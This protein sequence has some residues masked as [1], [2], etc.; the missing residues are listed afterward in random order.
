MLGAGPGGLQLGYYLQKSNAD[1]L[2]LDRES[3][4]GSTFQVHPR[5]RTLISINKRFT[6]SQDP[7]F[8]MR[9]DWNSLLCDDESF[10]FKNYDKQFFPS[11]DSLVTYMADYAERFDLNV[12]YNAAISSIEK[13]GNTY[14]L[15]DQ[16]GQ[17]YECECL[18]IATGVSKS[19]TPNIEGIEFSENYADMSLDLEGFEDK[20]V[21]II[22]KKNSAFESADHIVS[23]ASLIHLCS[24]QS[25]KMAWKTHYVGDLRAINNNVLDTYQLKSQN[26]ILD[27]DILR[28]EK[29]DGKL[30][31]TFCY[32][33]AEGEV[34]QIEYD[35]ILCCAGF[36]FDAS[37]F[38]DSAKPELAYMGKYPSLKNNFESVNCENMYFAGTI[39]HSLDYRKA[40][41]GFIHGFRYNSRA[42]ASLLLEKHENISQCSERT[43]IDAEQ[44]TQKLLSR[45]NRSGGLWQQ[46]GFIADVAARVGDEF[47]YINELPKDY[48]ASRTFEG[49]SDLYVLTLEYGA[50][51]VGDPFA[52]ERIHRENISQADDS[53]FLHPVVRRY[54]NG[55]L[56]A[57]HD[58]IEDLE[59]HWVEPEHIV[60]LVAFFDTQLLNDSP[61]KEYIENKYCSKTGMKI[62]AKTKQPEA[63]ATP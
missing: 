25:I 52:V 16:S 53:Q 39:T 13:I 48:I 37:I 54:Y 3:V 36:K 46:P 30:R 63:V 21:L 27:A 47:L 38:D 12:K 40:T 6:G 61:T 41:S 44:I 10:R 29:I 31:V 24:P 51:I 43:D 23:S 28:I 1:Y 32:D 8:N 42:L 59:S 17:D 2:I 60:P 20:R 58:V 4:A 45:V 18:I 26:A 34:E 35:R 33:H 5:H 62:V 11:A 50:P 7:E 49:S 56:V 14:H 15:T 22:G 9:H 19:N 57:R 55:K